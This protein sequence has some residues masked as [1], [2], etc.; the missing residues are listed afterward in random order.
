MD[1]MQVI[2]E[3][4]RR[5]ILRLVWREE[6]AAGEI[7]DRF[8]ISFPAVSQHL[9]TLR[10]AGVVRTRKEGTRRYYRADHD[11]LGPLR[12]VL[13]QM[14]TSDLGTLARAAEAA[15]AG[16]SATPATPSA[17]ETKEAIDDAR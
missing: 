2:A 7:A 14:W 13:E 10:E 12:A 4:R 16:T 15:H 6:M 5:Q 9:R 17:H 3:P 11:A 1:L 8:E